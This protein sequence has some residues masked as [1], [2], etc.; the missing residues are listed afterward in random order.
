LEQP[1]FAVAKQGP[2]QASIHAMVMPLSRLR[3]VTVEGCIGVG[4]TTLTH[5]VAQHLR[6]KPVLEIVEENPFLPEFYRDQV[7]HAFKT[8]MFFLLSRFKQQEALL[9]GDLFDGEGGVVSDYLFAKDRIFAELTL[10]SSEMGLY[11]QIFQALA[12]RIRR[13]DLIIYLHAPMEV[14]LERIARR[15]RSFE[16]DIDR[17]YLESLVDA[18][19]RFFADYSGAPVLMID[20]ADLNFPERAEDLDVIFETLGQFPVSQGDGRQRLTLAGRPPTSPP[21]TA[22][23]QQQNLL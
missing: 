1:H 13:P 7:A 8:Q 12:Q 20:T 11:D 10:S 17:G 16:K 4:K 23:P 18:Y 9:Q 14:I 22:K 15:G 5:L 3:Y 21:E 19:G 2:I 6:A